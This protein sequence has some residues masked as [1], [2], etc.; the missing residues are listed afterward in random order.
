MP[1]PADDDDPLDL[2]SSWASLDVPPEEHRK[3]LAAR[4]GPDNGCV[5]CGV[6][7]DIEIGDTP[8][9]TVTWRCCG[10]ERLVC[11]GC[12]LTIPDSRPRE[13][14]H[15]TFCSIPCWEKMGKPDE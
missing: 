5:V 12:T 2:A 6:G 1:E 4:S 3:W 9:E 10:C 14:Y 7:G 8:S 15:E 11:R 13:Y